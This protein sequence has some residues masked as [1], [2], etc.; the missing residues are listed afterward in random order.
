[1]DEHFVF[2]VVK[3]EIRIL[4]FDAVLQGAVLQGAVLQ[5]AVLHSEHKYACISHKTTLCSSIQGV[6]PKTFLN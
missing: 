3:E 4:F 6:P 2:C 5:G 1:M